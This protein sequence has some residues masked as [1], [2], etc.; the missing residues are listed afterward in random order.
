MEV[1]KDKLSYFETTS[2]TGITDPHKYLQESKK[3]SQI[4]SAY[5]NK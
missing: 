4:V 1:L 3:K 2:V 5:N